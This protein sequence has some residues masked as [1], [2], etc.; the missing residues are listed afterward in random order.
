MFIPDP[1]KRIGRINS[2]YLKFWN[3]LFHEIDFT[4]MNF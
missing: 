2:P 3:L 1:E 4:E